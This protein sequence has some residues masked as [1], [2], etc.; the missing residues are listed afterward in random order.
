M[1]P[2]EFRVTDIIKA[3][4][5]EDIGA[6]DIT[7]LA[8]ISTDQFGAGCF[9]ANDQG[10][11]CGWPVV[12]EVF[13]VINP[14][15][16]L[17]TLLPEGSS[18]IPGAL[19]AN[20]RGPLADL[21]LGERVALN[22]LQHLSGIATKTRIL[23]NL[24]KDFPKARLVDTRKTIPGLRV[25]QKYAVRVGGGHNHRFNLSD[26]VL[27][28]DNHIAFFGSLS[29]A[30]AAAREKIPHTMRIEVETENPA[31]VQEALVAGA[32]IIM[33]DNMTPELMAEMVK[34]IDGRALVEASGRVTAESIRTVAA[35]G[36]DII[37]VGALTHSV[38]ALD[39]SLKLEF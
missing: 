2:K 16:E 6:G 1:W 32:D 38:T 39:I 20:I 17:E 14:L 19:L 28:K 10:V 9:I 35:T 36:V 27:I 5:Q 23:A 18:V 7:T 30:V 37:S 11:I 12:K 21:L 31:Q 22:F 34:L 4:L 33:L 8:T 26:A 24:I 25:L 13:Q 3:A 29:S 15:I